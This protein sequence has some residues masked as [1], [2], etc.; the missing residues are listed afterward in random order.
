VTWLAVTGPVPSAVG[1]AG[2]VLGRIEVGAGEVG[3][4]TELV[5]V[6][7]LQNNRW[8]PR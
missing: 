7:C 6:V 8:L 4:G 2:A 3:E 1:G 5:L